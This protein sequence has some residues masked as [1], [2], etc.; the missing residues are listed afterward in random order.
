VIKRDISLKK[1][2]DFT[3]VQPGKVESGNS[4]PNF[5]HSFPIIYIEIEGNETGQN[6]RQ[7]QRAL[8]NAFKFIGFP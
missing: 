6:P 8:L 4:F 7:I 2:V 3:C 5:G 1:R